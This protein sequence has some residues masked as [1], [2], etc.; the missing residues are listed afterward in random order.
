MNKKKIIGKRVYLED[1]NYEHIV[2]PQYLS[3]VKDPIVMKYIG[4]PEFEKDV[5]YQKVEAYLENIKKNPNI[6]FFSVYRSE[7]HKFI[8]TAKLNF[9]DDSL[10][11]FGVADIGIMIGDK[12]QWGFGLGGEVISALSNFAF[13]FLN[14]RKLTAGASCENIGVIKVFEKNGYKKEGVLRSQLNFNGTY[15]DH[16]LLGC[17]P[18]ELCQ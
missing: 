6:H 1:F 13:K 16:V 5:T 10:I 8:G 11:R 12:E 14:A 4:R 3:W 9:F 7:N 2:N 17:F 18:E 15:V